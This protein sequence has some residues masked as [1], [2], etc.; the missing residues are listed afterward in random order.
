MRL[1]ISSRLTESLLSSS[2]SGCCVQAADGIEF[3]VVKEPCT[4]SVLRRQR[5][6]QRD[7]GSKSTLCF[8]GVHIMAR[9]RP[10]SILDTSIAYEAVGL[11][12]AL[13]AFNSDLKEPYLID[14]IA[15]DKLYEFAAESTQVRRRIIAT[16]FLQL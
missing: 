6:L 1:R 8:L 7:E 11:D 2:W 15:Y 14:R 9:K 10:L 3:E 13:A 5:L 4:P 16:Y 12:M